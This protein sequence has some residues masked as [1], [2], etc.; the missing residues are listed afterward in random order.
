MGIVTGR[1]I[2]VKEDPFFFV[3]IE[4]DLDGEIGIGVAIVCVAPFVLLAE[5]DEN[6]FVE[7]GLGGDK[8]IGLVVAQ[9]GG[10]FFEVFEGGVLLVVL[11]EEANDFKGLI[12]HALDIEVDFG[13]E[14]V[15]G[16]AVFFG[17]VSIGVVGGAPVATGDDDAA[18]GLFL[19]I[20]EQVE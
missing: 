18:A 9:E 13:S 10:P 2:E 14:L 12:F 6:F 1:F 15:F 20:V 17:R 8:G 4:A 16:A 7:P 3:S 19:E 5:F 11:E